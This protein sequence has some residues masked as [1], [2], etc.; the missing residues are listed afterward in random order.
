MTGVLAVGDSLLKTEDSWAS[1]LALALDEP[2]RC[3]AEGQERVAGVVDYQ[4]P[5]LDDGTR[6]SLAC[7]S[8][9]TNDVLDPAFDL[10]L[11]AEHLALTLARL[12]EVADQVAVSTLSLSVGQVA[13]PFDGHLRLR[14]EEVNRSITA[15]DAVVV[16]CSNIRGRRLVEADAIHPTLAGQL[17][18]ADRAAE[19]LGLGVQ[20]SLAVSEVPPTRWTLWF[21]RRMRI[22]AAKAAARVRRTG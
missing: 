12:S 17:L 3:I 16:P 4:L 1:W 20:P 15:T 2:L 18:I 5:Q 8:V 21:T 11:F 22:V 10:D 13:W 7:L 6:Y 9:G 19:A 14:A